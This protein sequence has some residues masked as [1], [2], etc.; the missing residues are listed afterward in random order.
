MDRTPRRET[1]CIYRGQRLPGPVDR[2][3]GICV[4]AAEAINK[5]AMIAFVCHQWDE[6]WCGLGGI[7][8]SGSLSFMRIRKDRAGEDDNPGENPTYRQFGE[9]FQKEPLVFASLGTE[10]LDSTAY[11]I[12]IH[13]ALLVNLILI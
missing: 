11:P 10:F 4:G 12:L 5:I 2:G 1:G 13:L 3:A 7:G 6:N 9:G 8:P